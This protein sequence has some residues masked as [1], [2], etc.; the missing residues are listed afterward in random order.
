MG[1]AERHRKYSI[2]QKLEVLR[3]KEE[4][5][6][7]NSE[8]ARK[9][10]INK[11]CIRDWAQAYESG[12]AAALS[13]K[14]PGKKNNVYADDFRVMVVNEKLSGDSTYTELAKKYNMNKCVIQ[15]WMRKYEAS[16]EEALRGDERG[17]APKS[18]YPRANVT[19]KNKNELTK[20]VYEELVRLRA[21]VAYLKKLNALAWE[22]QQLAKRKRLV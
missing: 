16:G 1:K 22:K 9:Y 10:G 14:V 8:L 19:K 20:E 6:L 21:E 5:H 11:T 3:D 15:L 13:T 12:G 18:A 7:S 17:R 4:N 2:E